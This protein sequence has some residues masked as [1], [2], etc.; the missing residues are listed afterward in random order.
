MG[1]AKIRYADIPVASRGTEQ[2]MMDLPGPGAVILSGINVA[3]LIDIIRRSELGY[4]RALYRFS[5][6]S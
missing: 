4:S 5:H 6:R 1:T 2:S 3:G